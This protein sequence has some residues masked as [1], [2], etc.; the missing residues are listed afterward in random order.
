M[1]CEEIEV[2]LSGLIDDQLPQQQRQAVELHLADCTPCDEI[3][4]SMRRNREELRMLTDPVL[5]KSN[6]P[7][8]IAETVFITND[9][10]G[11]R[12]SDGTGARQQQIAE[13]LEIG[14]ENYLS[15]L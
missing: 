3:C 14:I 8:V 7:A 5:L 6:M 9:A 11:R 12:L 2:Y 4:E 10:E 1:R 13:R 15:T